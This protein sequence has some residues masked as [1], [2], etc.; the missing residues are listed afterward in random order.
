MFI[1][2]KLHLFRYIASLPR[3]S[4]YSYQ[5]DSP[6][7]TFISSNLYFDLKQ[8]MNVIILKVLLHRQVT[9]FN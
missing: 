4:L 9:H 6:V 8:L 2:A 1:V 7:M 5:T 3:T